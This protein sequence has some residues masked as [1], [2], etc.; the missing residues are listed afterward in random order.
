[1]LCCTRVQEVCLLTP[2][3]HVKL[4]RRMW[5]ALT[6]SD[7]SL[8]CLLRAERVDKGRGGGGGGQP[9]RKQMQQPGLPCPASGLPCRAGS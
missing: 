4:S 7:C 1:M 2:A 9:P 5:G 8:A 6:A 3:L